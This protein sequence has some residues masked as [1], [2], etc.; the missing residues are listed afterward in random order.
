MLD[1]P[2]KSLVGREPMQD[3]LD[4]MFGYYIDLWRLT[5]DGHP[6]MTR[7]SRLL[8][9]RWRDRA[10]ILKTAVDAEEELGNALM[11]WW[12]GQGVP[13]VLAREGKTV[14]LE[15]AQDKGSLADLVRQGRDDEASCIICGVVAK[16]HLPKS[17]AIPDLIPLSEWF[18]E[19]APAADTYGGVLSRSAAAAHALLGAPREFGVLH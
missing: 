16:L 6:I 14:L 3:L 8:P 10:A 9:V 13:L 12:D 1:S 11:A 15:R 7:T 19:L 4:E 2:E 17:R 5:P 18:R